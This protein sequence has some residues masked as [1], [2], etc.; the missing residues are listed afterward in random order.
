MAY[1]TQRLTYHQAVFSYQSHDTYLDLSEPHLI[2]SRCPQF[3]IIKL[4]GLPDYQFI[5]LLVCRSS[6]LQCYQE[7][8]SIP[9]I[10]EMLLVYIQLK[11][12]GLF[13]IYLV[14]KMLCSTLKYPLRYFELLISKSPCKEIS[15][16]INLFI[17]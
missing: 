3:I 2:F 7:K 10:R 4:A 14:I 16:Y 5:Y 8:Y 6:S 12:L 13:I 17:D 9:I 1:I 15:T 11:N